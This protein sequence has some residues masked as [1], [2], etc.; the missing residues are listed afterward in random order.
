MDGYLNRR[1]FTARDFLRIL[2]SIAR[3]FAFDP[4]FMSSDKQIMISMRRAWLRNL[5]R[6][7]CRW[8]ETLRDTLDVYE[9][10]VRYFFLRNTL[11]TRIFGCAT[12][13]LLFKK[14]IN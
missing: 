2:G 4:P 6:E 10:F 3:K 7:I 13:I 12:K 5:Q 9:R 1:L 8:Q 11:L 14:T